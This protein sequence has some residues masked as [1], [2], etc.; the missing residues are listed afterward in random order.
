ME[1][2]DTLIFTYLLLIITLV[3]FGFYS[4]N[5]LGLFLLLGIFAWIT[6]IISLIRFFIK[7]FR[8]KGGTK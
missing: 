8:D 7:V 5:E 2:K 3:S 6:T 4:L 1:A